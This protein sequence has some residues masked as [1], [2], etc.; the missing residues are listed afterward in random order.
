MKFSLQNIKK[1]PNLVKELGVGLNKLD[2]TNNFEGFEVTVTIAPSTVA[3]IRNQLTFI[4]TRRIIFRQD[5]DAV[6]SDSS[7][8]WD[9]NFVYLENHSATNTV[10]LTVK[11]LR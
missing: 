10:T 2:F 9:I 7:N 3:K 4:P 1:L 5:T 11:F 8:A 6:I